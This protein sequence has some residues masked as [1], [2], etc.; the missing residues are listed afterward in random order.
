MFKQL[1]TVLRQV[2]PDKFVVYDF[3][4][5]GLSTTQDQITQI[6]A[7]SLT[8]DFKPIETL[9]VLVKP[10]LDVIANPMAALTTMISPSQQLKN[11]IPE[12]EATQKLLSLIERTETKYMLGYNNE[13][14][15]SKVLNHA[16]YRNLACPKPHNLF[17]TQLDAFKLVLLAQ[18]LRKHSITFEEKENGKPNL[19]LESL[20]PLNGIELTEAHNA[21]ADITATYQLTEL[22]AKREPTLFQYWLDLSNPYNVDTL[23]ESGDFFLDV[24]TAYGSKTRYTRPTFLAKK[25]KAG[26]FLLDLTLNF[27]TNEKYLFQKFNKYNTPL[28]TEVTEQQGSN[29]LIDLGFD[30]DLINEQLEK[31]RNTDIDAL[32]NEWE[33]KH[34]KEPKDWGDD[35]YSDSFTKF[36]PKELCDV[37]SYLNGQP[38]TELCT[39]RV[40]QIAERI[41]AFQYNCAV[42]ST[43]LKDY[44][45]SKLPE[46]NKF[47]K[48]TIEETTKLLGSDE[49]SAEQK[50]I[51]KD[52]LTHTNDQ[53]HLLATLSQ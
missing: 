26:G 11:G 49:T 32:F 42:E 29:L 34:K 52:L 47:T 7:I 36:G 10:R 43:K 2:S 31:A 19:K 18:S 27:D 22:L 51:L 24:N 46:N 35:P 20:C 14:F 53:L 44:A 12:R 40:K 17:L 45:R 50:E 48:E 4:S 6:G 41:E 13:R 23:T 16:A 9:D 37:A 33:A 8:Q 3:E 25:N 1:R 5:S 21:L 39:S 38:S 15:D 30:S 28:L